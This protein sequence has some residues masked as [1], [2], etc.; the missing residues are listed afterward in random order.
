MA[1]LD[2]VMKA[3]SCPSRVWAMDRVPCPSLKPV[4]VGCAGSSTTL[5]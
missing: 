4:A 3:S 2:W 5:S 1:P